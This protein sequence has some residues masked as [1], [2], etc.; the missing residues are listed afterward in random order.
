MTQ[1]IIIQN[2]VTITN[3]VVIRSGTGG[4]PPSP[5][6]PATFYLLAEDGDNLV[7]ELDEPIIQEEG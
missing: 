7:T 5:P 2:G 3:G 1:S 6:P 4:S